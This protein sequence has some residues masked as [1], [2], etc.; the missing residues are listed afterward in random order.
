MS[1]TIDKSLIVLH[2]LKL[3]SLSYS[4]WTRSPFSP[5]LDG[6]SQSHLTGTV[7]VGPKHSSHLYH[8]WLLRL[9]VLGNVLIYHP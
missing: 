2:V 5:A 9:Q 6:P 7:G 4:L 1:V 8:N 3:E